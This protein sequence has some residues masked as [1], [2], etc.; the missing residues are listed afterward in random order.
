MTVVHVNLLTLEINKSLKLSFPQADES[1]YY[2][3]RIFHYDGSAIS[4][5]RAQFTFKIVQGISNVAKTFSRSLLSFTLHATAP[6]QKPAETRFLNRFSV[7]ATTAYF[8]NPWQ[9]YNRAVKTVARRV[10]LDPFFLYPAGSYEKINGDLIF[11]GEFGFRLIRKLRVHLTGSFGQIN[12]VFELFPNTSKLPPL[13]A[14]SPA[15]HQKLD[16]GVKS[17]GLGFSYEYSIGKNLAC[18]LKSH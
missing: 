9:N 17:I 2:G 10:E 5:H 11:R 6:A 7:T 13:G 16:F 1:F 15:F 14:G 3:G 4:V 8:R 18:S 12:S